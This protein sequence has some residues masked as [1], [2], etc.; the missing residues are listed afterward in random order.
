MRRFGLFPI[1]VDQSCMY[2]LTHCYRGQAPSHSK[3][4]PTVSP[5]LQQA[6]CHIQP[7]LIFMKR[8]TCTSPAPV[9]SW[10]SGLPRNPLCNASINGASSNG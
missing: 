7:P 9:K 3:P 2:W 4:P 10:R 8:T 5:L 1:A 6:P